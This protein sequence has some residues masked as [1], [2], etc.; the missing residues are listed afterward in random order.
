MTLA[1]PGML[2]LLLLVPALA[3]L[4]LRSWRRRQRAVLRGAGL[5]QVRDAAG[6]GP[7]FRRHLPAVFFFLGFTILI[8]ALARP[9]ARIVLPAHRGT[10]ILSMDISGSM[11]AKDI[12]PTRMQAVKDAAAG[13]V[14][15]QPQGVRIGVVA[16]SGTA[17]LVQP[18]TTEKNK[19]LAAVDRLEP[20]MF[21]A[22]GSGLLTALDAIFP[23]QEAEAPD[24]ANAPLT[25]AAPESEPPPVAPGSYT[26]A[27]IILLTDG[28]SN[29]GPDP[30]DVADKAARLG[31]RVFT[32]GVGTKEGVDLSFGGFT[33]HA[34]LDEATLRKIALITGGSYFKAGSAEELHGIYKSLSTR[35]V[36]ERQDTELTAPLVAAALVL[37]VLMGA[38]SLAWFNRLL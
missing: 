9:S 7:G 24:S 17:L 38:I 31:V 6:R 19:V 8:L 29:Q 18:P 32:V 35:M 21:T 15:A 37:F 20:Q 26:S 23:P 10:V 27:A 11:R 16:F 4:Y 14:K 34:I 5:F 33:F 1:W 36:L 12:K 30:L 28:Q 13:F 2:W 3:A 22:I 25:H